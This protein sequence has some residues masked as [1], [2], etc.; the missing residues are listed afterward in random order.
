[1]K[2]Y[3]IYFRIIRMLSHLMTKTNVSQ[4]TQDKLE[5]K[6]FAFAVYSGRL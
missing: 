4:V 1:M 3:L 5:I 2:N 6:A